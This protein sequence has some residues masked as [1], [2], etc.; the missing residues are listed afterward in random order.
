MHRPSDDKSMNGLIPIPL[1][2]QRFIHLPQAKGSTERHR[3][4]RVEKL[5]GMFASKLFAGL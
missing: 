3:F 2:L 5:I 4:I 1:H